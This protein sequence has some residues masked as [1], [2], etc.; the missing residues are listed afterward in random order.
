M[1]RQS[2]NFEDFFVTSTLADRFDPS[3]SDD[4]DFVAK[5]I[6]NGLEEYGIIDYKGIEAEEFKAS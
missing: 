1:I 4:A 3:G 6:I 2:C 5:I